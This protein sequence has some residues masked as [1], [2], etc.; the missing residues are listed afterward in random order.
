[1]ST[2]Q[3][4][5]AR[6]VI[7]RRENDFDGHRWAT[8]YSGTCCCCCCCLHW[9]GAVLGGAIGAGRGS[10]PPPGQIKH[11]RARRNSAI[12]GLVGLLLAVLVLLLS[13]Q[14][15]AL[16][17]PAAG[18]GANIFS[19]TLIL[20]A[21]VPCAVFVPVLA[22][23]LAGA[24]LTPDDPAEA[25]S[26]GG[27]ACLGC[28]YD[29]RGSLEQRRCPECGQTFAPLALPR[30]MESK[31]RFAWRV[32]GRCLGLAVLGTLLGYG[33]M[34]VIAKGAGWL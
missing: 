17:G 26:K 6:P 5:Q 32:G 19:S 25:T 18:A 28:G 27:Y 12:G 21:F 23:M 13:W 31:Y 3:E 9:L 4:P 34:L 22:G 1:M 7:L 14:F 11:A 16:P 33:I 10:Q 15:M 30:L 2:L 29:L 8:L 20:V 24:W